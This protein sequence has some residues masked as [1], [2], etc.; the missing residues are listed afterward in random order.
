MGR[1]DTIAERSS[2]VAHSAEPARRGGRRIAR[3]TMMGA[4]RMLLVAVCLLA[5]NRGSTDQI[6]FRGQMFKLK[7]AYATYED[8]KDD[9]DN[10]APGEAARASQVIRA[11]AVPTQLDGR[12]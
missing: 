7:H 5:C 6:A 9:S 2:P 8:Y 11:M 1:S 4:V 10:L 3:P 12:R